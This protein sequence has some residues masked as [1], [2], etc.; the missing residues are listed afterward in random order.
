MPGDMNVLCYFAAGY[1]KEIVFLSSE[2]HAPGS[3][4]HAP[5]WLLKIG[6][7][8]LVINLAIK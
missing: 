7:S 2:T 8:Q 4:S 1:Q 6:L 3:A 5:E